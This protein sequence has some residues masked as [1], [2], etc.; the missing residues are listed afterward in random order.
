[1]RMDP[2]IAFSHEL[3]QKGSKSFALAAKLLPR[4]IRYDAMMLYAWCR[5]CD[6]VI[7][8]QVLGFTRADASSQS[9]R[10]RLDLLREKT[11]QALEGKASEPVFIALGRVAQKHGVPE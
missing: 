7:D 2:I 9:P 11:K 8:D 4:S 3:I 10:Q 1:M 5:H 6:D